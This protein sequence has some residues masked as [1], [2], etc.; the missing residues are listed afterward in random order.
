L[1]WGVRGFYYDKMVSTDHTIAEIK[2]ILKKDGY[3]KSDDL[4]I[5]VASIPMHEFGKSNMIKL[6]FVE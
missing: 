5:N 1:V 2:D 6:S 4:M 3:V